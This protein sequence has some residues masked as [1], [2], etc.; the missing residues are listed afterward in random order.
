MPD[1]HRRP[2]PEPGRRFLKKYERFIFSSVD[3]SIHSKSK[4]NNPLYRSCLYIYIYP[5][6]L[7]GIIIKNNIVVSFWKHT[8]IKPLLKLK[9]YEVVYVLDHK[10]T[11]LYKKVVWM[12]LIFPA[13]F[14]LGQMIDFLISYKSCWCLKKILYYSKSL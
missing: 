1:T 2:K 6:Y 10:A 7:Y 8:H 12:C 14:S 4:K 13:F 5:Y 3:L 9:I 11:L